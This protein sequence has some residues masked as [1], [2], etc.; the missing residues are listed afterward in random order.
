MIK[1]GLLV[2]VQLPEQRWEKVEDSRVFCP[3]RLTLG[4]FFNLAFFFLCKIKLQCSKT[5]KEEEVKGFKALER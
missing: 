3:F 4:R 2:S 5:Q 1:K